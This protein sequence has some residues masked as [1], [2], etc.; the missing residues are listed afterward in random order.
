MNK[1]NFIKTGDNISGEQVEGTK[2]PQGDE[3][4]YERTQKGS[5]NLHGDGY[6][7]SES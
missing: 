4:E 2:T 1:E 6:V 3:V 7:F 5:I